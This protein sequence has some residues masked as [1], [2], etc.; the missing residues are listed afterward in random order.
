MNRIMIF[1]RPGSGKS[2]FALEL[3]KRIG[4]PLYHLDKYFYVAHW[5]ERDYTEFIKIQKSLVEQPAWIIDGNATKS[6]ELRY[7]RATT[8][9][10]F[11]YP[12]WRCYIRII[13]RLFEDR[14]KFDDRAVQCPERIT[15]KLLV[16]MW[17]FN[18]RVQEKVT[19]L[20]KMYPETQFFEVRNDGAFKQI[21]LQLMKSTQ[22]QH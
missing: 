14:S 20:R 1:G 16:Y 3:N 6:L 8:C 5:I 15:W 11:N 9:L 4:I 7:A 2:T 19:M 12:R 17:T 18:K 13:K 10:Y 22:P 21:L